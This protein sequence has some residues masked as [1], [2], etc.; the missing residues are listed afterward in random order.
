[1]EEGIIHNW[2][3]LTRS[4]SPPGARGANQPVPNL[5]ML[6]FP[7]HG[8]LARCK[9]K[10][11]ELKIFNF[12]EPQMS[13]NFFPFERSSRKWRNLIQRK[14]EIIPESLRTT[15]KL[16]EAEAGGKKVSS[17][18]QICM[19]LPSRLGVCQL[20]VNGSRAQVRDC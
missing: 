9:K 19:H 1:M 12:G 8:S 15:G 18:P 20:L 13:R 14:T 17:I 3:L 6:F 4:E 2:E 16:A 10:E 7:Y 5:V 11:L